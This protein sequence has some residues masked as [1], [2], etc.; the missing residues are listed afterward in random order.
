MQH[1]EGKFLPADLLASSINVNPLATPTEHQHTGSQP[2]L[3]INHYFS[4][5]LPNII[6]FLS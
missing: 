2:S 6:C 5:I 1:G 4:S 3:Y